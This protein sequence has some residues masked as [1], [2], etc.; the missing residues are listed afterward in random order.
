MVVTYVGNQPS[1]LD[2]Y[3]LTTEAY[4]GTST[5]T[6]PVTTT[7][8]PDG[9]GPGEIK[10][11]TPTNPITPPSITLTSAY[12]GTSTL[13]GPITTTIAPTGNIPELV[14][15][16]TPT[17]PG[18]TPYVTI[19]TAHTG[20]PPIDEPI[21]ITVPPIGTEPGTIIVETPP[22]EP[23]FITKVVAHTGSSSIDE[24]I[25]TTIPPIGSQP[26]TVLIET[27]PL[28]PH[29]ITEV[30]PYTGTSPILEAIT[31]TI[32]ASGT[33]P[34]TIIIETP[35]LTLSF[36]T[37][38]IPHTG[39]SSITEA[40][41]TTI[42][43]SGTEPGTIV[44]ETPPLQSSTTSEPSSTTSKAPDPTYSCT[45]GGFLMQ[46]NSLY[47]LDLET[48]ENA[49]I[50]SPVGP[51]GV[52]HGIGYNSLD[53]FIYGM[54]TVEG[55][56]QL[57]RID[58]DGGSTLLPLTFSPATINVGDID[59]QGQYW[60]SAGGASWKQIDLKPG[61]PTF[62]TIVN[63]GTASGP[64]VSDWAYLRNG[65][66]YLYSIRVGTTNSVAYRWSRTTH[67]WESLR[68]FG[69]F[70]GAVGFGA[71]YTVGDELWGSN[72]GSG[73][74][75]AFPV[76]DPTAPA[77]TVST[78]FPSTVNDGARCLNAPGLSS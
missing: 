68:D 63:Q 45:P 21:T 16:L 49:L 67:V 44:I 72:N 62:G 57:I 54:V 6:T 41:T 11:L 18:A 71:F 33:E 48:G 30:D 46:G 12:T 74:I 69:N 36:V 55:R 17:T 52:M 39:T 37:E 65:G 70:N 4:T 61:S 77:R 1:L 23:T 56:T 22:V 15:V 73:D 5:L 60:I 2:G 76:L 7:I 26:G 50:K 9:G 29:F 43:P 19:T 20:T 28:E 32:P 47:R 51:G 64:S 75:V 40:I 53:D 66:D 31:T 78:G 42:P 35:V 8:P 38:E 27:P 14:L 58:A 10:V 3:V 25:T 13:T 59:D 34:G 24:A